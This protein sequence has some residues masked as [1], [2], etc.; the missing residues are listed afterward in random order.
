LTGSVSSV[1]AMVFMQDSER[2]ATLAQEYGVDAGLHLN[3]TLPFST[4][5][6]PARLV[7][8]QQR[9]AAFLRSSRF[10]PAMYHPGLAGSFRYVVEAQLDE[11]ARLYGF[12]P[13]RIDGHHHMH[14]AAN[15]LGQKLLPAGTIARRNFSFNRGE[16]FL[17][18]RL[19]RQ[20]QNRLLA[21]RH[22]LTDFFFD[23]LP[24]DAPRL[25]KIA[26]VS[27]AH[28]VEIETHPTDPQQYAF[29]MRGEL[30][31]IC[32]G[33]EIAKGYALRDPDFLEPVAA[34]RRGS[35]TAGP[36]GETIPHICICVCTYKRPLPLRRLLHCLGGQ[37]TGGLF[38]YSIVV[39]DNDEARSAEATVGE[40]KTASSVSMKYCHEPARGIARAR[41]KA[42]ANAE[43]DFIAMIDD[44]EFPAPGWLLKLFTTYKSYHVG[45][46]LGPVKRHFDE[47]PPEWLKKS[48]LYDRSVNPTGK[49]VDWREARTGNALVKR[50]LFLSDGEPFRPEFKSGEDRD[51][52]RRKMAEGNEFVW[53]AE[54]EVFE[55]IPPARWTRSYYLKKA[56]LQGAAFALR[57]DCGAR[58]ILKSAVAIPL[59]VA[60]LPF[61]LLAGQHHFMTLMVK[62]CDHAG[63]LLF[64]MGIN[65]IREEYVSD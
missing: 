62:L 49:R 7:E 42:T 2:A 58:S 65:P 11:Y 46:V 14:L 13:R 31:A 54:A 18:N 61:A 12:S 35:E 36:V 64:K 53:S 45:G 30:A 21:R 51:F 59:Y 25:E 9:I 44:D 33:V 29:L 27:R 48:G 23:L 55:V 28:N 39:A 15:V 19:Y 1:S 20:G 26:A 57:P 52:F 24:L 3:L 60:A 10:A 38:T 6:C 63:K 56:L 17:F 41:N 40:A 34:Q 5:R 8:H 47:T 16:K 32:P 43:G 37:E 50:A 4:R 22:R